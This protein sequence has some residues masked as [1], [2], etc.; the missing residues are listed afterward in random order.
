MIYVGMDVSSKSFMIHAINERKKVVLKKE[1]EPTRAGLREMVDE[2]GPQSKVIVFEAGNQL[3]WIALTLR[4]IDSVDVHVVHPNE[5]NWIIKSKKKTD[6]VDAKK[7]AELAR[8]DMLPRKVHVVEGKAR[9]LR[10]LA[11]ARSQLQSKRVGL[12]NTIRGYMKQEGVR[13]PAKFFGSKNRSQELRDLKVS[14]SLKIIIESF[15]K[16]IEALEK[17]EKEIESNLC[18][19]KDSRIELLESIPSI[20]KLTARILV[21]A[22]DDVN[23]FESKKSIARYGALTPT[24]YQS[25]DVIQLGRINNDGRREV[26]GILLQCAHCIT[27][28]KSPAVK[29]LKDFFERIAA[30]RGK[31]IAIVALAR[32]LLTTSFGVLRNGEF[33]DPKMLAA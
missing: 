13:L 15:L 3:K 33:Y 22:I 28:M 8:A 2:L 32:K 31:K 18:E 12:V 30:K 24:L 4:K 19:I 25:G 7:L 6:K 27:R 5:V 20:G 26:R 23:R 9:E 11:A 17:C 21:G 14:R 10:E 16:G 29:P 1:I